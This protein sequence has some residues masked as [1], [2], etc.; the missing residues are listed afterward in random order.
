MGK[1]ISDGTEEIKIK[2]PS[3]ETTLRELIYNA[4]GLI[5]KETIVGHLGETFYSRM[6]RPA[7]GVIPYEPPY[8]SSEKELDVKTDPDSWIYYGKEIAEKMRKHIS[9]QEGEK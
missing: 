4:K 5:L 1:G 9:A 3:S 8:S 2:I 7:F 6:E